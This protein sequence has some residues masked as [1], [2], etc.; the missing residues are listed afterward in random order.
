MKGKG[1]WTTKEGWPYIKELF[2]RTWGITVTPFNRDR[3]NFPFPGVQGFAGLNSISTQSG[4]CVKTYQS[5][6][7]NNWVNTEWIDGENGIS[8]VT[9]LKPDLS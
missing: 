7:F 9:A 2:E 3:N 1:E 5:D 6:V 8:K 4:L